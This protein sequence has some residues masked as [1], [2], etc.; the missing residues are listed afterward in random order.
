MWGAG[1]G[2]GWWMVFG[3]LLWLAFLG[4]V[5]YFLVSLVGDHRRPSEGKDENPIEIAKRRY[6]SGQITGEE[7]ERIRRDIA[8]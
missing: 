1:A 6:A 2:M 3:G 7:F 8:A 4:I 5:F